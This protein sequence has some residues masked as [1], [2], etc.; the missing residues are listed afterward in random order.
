MWHGLEVVRLAKLVVFGSEAVDVG[1]GLGVE[2]AQYV[3]GLVDGR[4]DDELTAHCNGARVEG[5]T[6]KLKVV[7]H[8]TLNRNKIH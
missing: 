5:A 3:A 4:D 1:A 8:V 2:H 7:Q 6:V